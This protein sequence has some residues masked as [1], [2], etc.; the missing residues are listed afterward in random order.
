MRE[1][2]ENIETTPFLAWNIEILERPQVKLQNYT[3]FV[4]MPKILMKPW[5]ILRDQ[6]ENYKTTP[7]CVYALYIDSPYKGKG[8]N[9]SKA[10]HWNYTFSCINP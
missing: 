2:T 5:N 6:G 10:K 9:V 4:C 7:F 3:V 1:T 8:R